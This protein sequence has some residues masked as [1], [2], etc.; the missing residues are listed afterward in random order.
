MYQRF[1]GSD[2]RKYFK[3]NGLSVQRDFLRR[4]N[5]AGARQYWN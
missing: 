3:T 2:K 4:G 1:Q 5:Q